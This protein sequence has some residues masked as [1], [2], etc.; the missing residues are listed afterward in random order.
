MATLWSKQASSNEYKVT[1]AGHAVRLYRNGVLH[2]QWNPTR[3]VAG[4][5]W[6]LFL[7]SS[8]GQDIK[9]VLVLGTGGGA[10]VNLVHS[11]FPVA[12]IDAIELDENHIYAARRFF[13][14]NTSLCNLHQADATRWIKRSK[15][16]KYDLI[17]DDVFFEGQGNPYR[18]VDAH[19]KW[20]R[21]LLGKLSLNGVLVINF[22]DSREWRLSKHQLEHNRYFKHYNF[23]S[24]RHK[25]CENRI[26]HI[27]RRDLSMATLRQHM[28]EQTYKAFKKYFEA[29]VYGY[30]SIEVRVG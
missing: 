20:I 17:I 28:Q 21:T 14:V 3:P 25:Q 6:D 22:A 10:V 30:R 2:S 4:H 26:I 7:L 23:A 8:L 1:R 13:K 18:S 19:A 29:G 12:K 15:Q 11:F 9:R 27:S 5:L 16:N 24:S